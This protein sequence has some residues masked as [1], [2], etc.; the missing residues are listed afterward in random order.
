MKKYKLRFQCPCGTYCTPKFNIASRGRFHACDA[1]WQQERSFTVEWDEPHKAYGDVAEAHGIAGQPQEAQEVPTAN[2]AKALRLHEEFRDI[3]L[4]AFE[5]WSNTPKLRDITLP[6]VK[7][8]GGKFAKLQVNAL[9]WA[10]DRCRMQGDV[11]EVD[12]ILKA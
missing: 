6:K 10:I 12:E 8:L 4:G 5:H 1:C 3:L 11:P 7:A 2:Y 9:Q